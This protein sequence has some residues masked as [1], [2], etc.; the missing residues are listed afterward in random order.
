[1]TY[2]EFETKLKPFLNVLHIYKVCLN[3]IK[4]DQ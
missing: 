4:C 3:H 2:N 1:L